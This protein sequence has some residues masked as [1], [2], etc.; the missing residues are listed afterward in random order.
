MTREGW[1]MATLSSRDRSA[2]LHLRSEGVAVESLASVLL[3]CVLLLGLGLAQAFSWA[4]VA[5]LVGVA[6]IQALRLLPYREDSPPIN[7]LGVDLD[8]SPN[9]GGGTQVDE[10]EPGSTTIFGAILV[11]IAMPF[12]AAVVVIRFAVL[13]LIPTLVVAVAAFLAIE[14]GRD[15]TWWQV[16]LA[17]VVSWGGSVALAAANELLVVRPLADRKGIALE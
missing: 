13:Y 14:T 11:A 2:R 4:V 12:I 9:G 16:V 6:A 7:L 3:S 10:G 8:D 17:V 1:N 5:G 15:L